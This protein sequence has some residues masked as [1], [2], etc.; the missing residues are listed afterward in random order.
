[1]TAPF[2]DDDA[3]ARQRIRESLDESLIVEAAAGTG[4]TSELVRRIV[5]VL[6]SGRA[7]VE[8]IVAVTFTRKAA[9]E[10][11]L[12]LRHALDEA[13][14]SASGPE[15]RAALERS[16]ARLEGAR[17]GT[18]DAFCAQILRERPVEAG[19]D[20]DFQ[21]LSE[22][23]R[24]LFR[25]AFRRWLESHLAE[26][27]PGLRRAIE[28]CAAS[29][30]DSPAARQLEFAAWKLAEQ[31]DSSA[32][33]DRPPGFELETAANGILDLLRRLAG[34]LARASSPK[35]NLVADLRPAAELMNWIERGRVIDTIV[36]EG[37]FL[38]LGRE[39][40]DRRR[41]RTGRGVFGDGVARQD[42]IEAR[43]RLLFAI[44]DLNR[45]GGAD[46]AVS[47]RGE[48]QDLLEGYETLKREHGCLDFLDIQI[49]VRDLIKSNAA[50][51]AHLQE[52]FTHLFIDE[53]QDTDPLQAQILILLSA[54]DPAASDWTAVTPRPGKLFLVGDPKQSI[55]RFRRADVIL[56]QHIRSTLAGRG[57][58]LV[59]LGRSYRSVRPIQQPLNLAFAS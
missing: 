34:L 17:I 7:Q 41:K 26:S 19:V 56:Y 46:L 29:W 12:R 8:N 52:R 48:M 9:G 42:V 36:L 2:P 32:P 58:G 4:K 11:K 53:F 24:S 27:G 47:L 15:E 38:Q 45:I 51:R 10:L 39:L 6:R 22:R 5:G 50:V 1:M 59:C 18:I 14:E 54:D 20:P 35:D 3:S 43:D 44:D 49:R 57:V 40:G 55:Y 21:V 33:W 23:D 28:R 30:N 25:L 37:R 13:R 16:A 31:R